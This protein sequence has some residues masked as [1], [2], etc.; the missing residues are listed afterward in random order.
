LSSTPCCQRDRKEACKIVDR[1]EL[2]LWLVSG[3]APTY[4]DSRPLFFKVQTTNSHIAYE[5]EWLSDSIRQEAKAR[6][7]LLFWAEKSLTWFWI[8]ITYKF[9]VITSIR[10][11]RRPKRLAETWYLVQFERSYLSLLKLKVGVARSSGRRSD[12]PC[13]RGAA[14]CIWSA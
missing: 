2:E 12:S 5:I 3:D 8:L 11:R 14:R 6:W 9:L 10:L 4:L 1:F 7:T 13:A